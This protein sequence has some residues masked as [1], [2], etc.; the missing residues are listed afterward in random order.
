MRPAPPSPQRGTTLFELLFALGIVVA[1]LCAALPW[2]GDIA[3][4]A[5]LRSGIQQWMS[6]LATARSSAVSS[7][8][9][10][11]ACPAV[12]ARCLDT[13]WWHHGWILFLDGNHN[14][15]H[16]DAEPILL[17]GGPQDG[18]QIASSTARQRIRYQADGSS[19]GSNVSLTFC[20]RRGLAS[21][22]TIVI[23]NA[24]RARAGTATPQQARLACA[25]LGS[26]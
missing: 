9:T 15:Q 18:V 8:G 13:T 24:G 14:S 2:F 22:R 7:G 16:D 11:V 17:R 19:S 26:G 21:A 1:S 4:A 12:A 20:D 5:P 6:T 3:A 25:G 23:N 10:V